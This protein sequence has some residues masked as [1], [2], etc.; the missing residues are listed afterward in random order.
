MNAERLHALA[1]AIKADLDESKIVDRLNSLADAAS[2]LAN[3]PDNMVA[4]TARAGLRGT[5][6]TDSR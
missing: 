2:Q 3:Q 6:N 5:V 4:A 1:K